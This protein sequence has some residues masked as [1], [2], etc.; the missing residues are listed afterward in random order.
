MKLG[1]YLPRR[2]KGETETLQK[3][4]IMS[5]CSEHQIAYW[6]VEIPAPWYVEVHAPYTRNDF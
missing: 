6:W 1:K 3:P 5:G 2:S 4:V